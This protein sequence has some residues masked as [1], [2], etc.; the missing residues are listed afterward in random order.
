MPRFNTPLPTQVGSVVQIILET[1]TYGQRC[2]NSFYYH[3]PTPGTVTV[4][5]L[6]NL[7]TD[8]T[9]AFDTKIKAVLSP[10]TT[11]TSLTLAERH[12]GVTPTRVYLY[13]PATIGTAGATAL[14]L[15]V[16][17]VIEKLSNFKGQH[18][19]GRVEF[20]AIPN[21]FT[22]PATDNGS[23]NATG[24]TAYGVVAA[25]MLQQINSGLLT[26][27]PII[28]TQPTQPFNLIDNSAVLADC[29]VRTILGTQTRRKS[30]RGI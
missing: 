28:V 18:G 5:D 1:T 19:R 26:W 8:W 3:E 24:I 16:T 12:Y 30:G 14:P 10:V 29:T 20:P 23:L 21:T 6:D 15:T 22:T 11:L 17:A 27:S 2:Q 7:K 25:E 4:A 13:A 9:A